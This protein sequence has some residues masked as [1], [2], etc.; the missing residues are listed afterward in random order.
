MIN[1]DREGNL[2]IKRII[3]H[4]CNFYKEYDIL[5]DFILVVVGIIGFY[6]TSDYFVCDDPNLRYTISNVC[7]AAAAVIAVPEF[8]SLFFDD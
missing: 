4:I 8:F 5:M 6:V 7:L 2:I 1:D 3:K